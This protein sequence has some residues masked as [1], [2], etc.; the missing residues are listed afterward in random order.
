MKLERTNRRVLREEI[1]AG[2]AGASARKH[3]S[4]NRGSGGESITIFFE[5]SNVR[6][7]EN[8]AMKECLALASNGRTRKLSSAQELWLYFMMV[9]WKDLI[10]SIS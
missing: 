3:G 8:V 5:F 4:K 1:L 2:I 6:D 9:S 10:K 7:G